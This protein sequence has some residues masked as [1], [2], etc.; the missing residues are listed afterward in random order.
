MSIKHMTL[1][2][3]H[4]KHEGS[5]LLLLLAIADCAN[6]LGEAWPGHR[7][8]AQRIRLSRS[9]VQYLLAKIIKSHELKII[10]RGGSGTADANHYRIALKGQPAGP[11]SQG[12]PAGPLGPVQGQSRA[13]DHAQILPEPLEPL[14]PINTNYPP[15][16]P[17]SESAAAAAVANGWWNLEGLIR[18]GKINKVRAI[19]IMAL[20][21]RPAVSAY[22]SFYL[23]AMTKPKINVP[24][25]FAAKRLIDEPGGFAGEPFDGLAGIGPAELAKCLSWITDGGSDY[26]DG[27]MSLARAFREFMPHNSQPIIAHAINELGLSA[28]IAKSG[29][30]API[31]DD[32]DAGPPPPHREPDQWERLIAKLFDEKLNRSIT[33][34][35]HR[36]QLVSDDTGKLLV[37]VPTQ[38]EFD[39]INNRLSEN[40]SRYLVEFQLKGK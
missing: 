27:H 23:Y 18:E 7:F 35:L 30:A 28:L 25:L 29:M 22:V 1:V 36:C 12:Q 9:A 10:H 4:S 38:I 26:L 19:E 32:G 21:P 3:E 31:T 2:W 40:L 5:A 37:E 17:Q 11:K 6:E 24:S 39:W 13:S 20:V 15:P 16:P 34:R 33:E 14:E 8:L